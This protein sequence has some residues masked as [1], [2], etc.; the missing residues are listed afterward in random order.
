MLACCLF[1][2][3]G[4]RD[5][6]VRYRKYFPQCKLIPCSGRPGKSYCPSDRPKRSNGEFKDCGVW[7]IEFFDDSKQWQSLTFKDIRNK[8][9]AEKR[10]TLFIS[11]RERGKLNLPRKKAILTLAEYA[12]VYLGFYKA[13]KENT[14]LAKERSIRTLVSYLGDYTLNKV[15][16]FVIEKFR[17]D[18]REKDGVKDGSINDDVVILSHLFTTAIKA[19][20]L[21]KNPCKDIKRLK[22]AQTRDK[23]LTNE[24]VSLLFEKLHGK[25]RFMILT[26]LFTGMRLNE[27]LRLKWTDI[28]FA[29]GL[30]TFTQSKTNKLVVMPLSSYLAKAFR[31]YKTSHTCDYLFESRKITHAMVNRYSKHF[32]ALF[33]QLGIDNFTFHNLRHSF[34]SMQ[35]DTGADIVTTKELLGH[36]DITTTMRYSHKQID[37][38]R[39]AIERIT[40]H[41][42]GIDKDRVLPLVA[43]AGTT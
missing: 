7:C 5:M 29:K 22:V 14:R 15:T 36:S 2:F 35:S 32:S 23:V 17:I 43:Q 20:I 8:T 11:D 30:I 13:A 37:V 40:D 41:I 24:E 16:P 25:D 33:K 10:L 12:G 18:R 31:E 3:E 39:N 28:D 19:G 42:L 6:A 34:A 38:K 9:E 1:L 4:R 27:V 21:D 26:G